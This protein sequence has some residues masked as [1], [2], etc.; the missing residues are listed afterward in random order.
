MV[1]IHTDIIPNE[2]MWNELICHPSMIEATSQKNTMLQKYIGVVVEIFVDATYKW[3]RKVCWIWSRCRV[4]R[5]LKL[6]SAMWFDWIAALL[7]YFQSIDKIH[8]DQFKTLGNERL[9]TSSSSLTITLIINMTALFTVYATE[10]RLLI[11]SSV[12]TGLYHSHLPRWGAQNSPHHPTG[13]YVFTTQIWSLVYVVNWDWQ[14][15]VLPILCNPNV[16]I[17]LL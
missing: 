3:H 7:Q 14:S 1:N 13:L 17:K 4:I 12:M 5:L 6:I 16:I 10:W 9:Y 11:I 15:F 8:I 2:L